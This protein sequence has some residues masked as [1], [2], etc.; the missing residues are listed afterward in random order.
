[1]TERLPDS[2]KRSSVSDDTFGWIGIAL[3][4]I[5]AIILDKSSQ[6]HQWHAAIM[7][8]FCALFGVLI[9]GRE[10]RTS[11][12]FWLF[13]ATC[14]ALHV[15]AIV[16]DLRSSAAALGSGNVV[17]GPASLHGVTAPCRAVLQVGTNIHRTALTVEIR[18]SHHFALFVLQNPSQ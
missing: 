12:L 13:W 4:L 2:R 9:F 7:W 1:M 3:V 8:T 11:L 16:D 5:A 6:P 18:R 10:K 17:R 15:V 14:L